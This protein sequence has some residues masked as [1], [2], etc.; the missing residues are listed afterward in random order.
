MAAML[1]MLLDARA[2]LAPGSA[3]AG[4]LDWRIRLT[5]KALLA[6]V[7]RDLPAG[8]LSMRLERFRETM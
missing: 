2:K 6:K 8:E 5:A 3:L 7:I 4:T 1:Y